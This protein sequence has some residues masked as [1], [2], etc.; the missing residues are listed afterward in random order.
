MLVRVVASYVAAIVAAAVLACIVNTQFTLAGLASFGMEVSLSDRLSATVHDVL[1]MGPPYMVV[2]AVGFVIAFVF[3][4]IL[5]RWVPGSRTVWF[6]AAGA[7]AVVAAI[8]IIKYNLGGTVVGAA[9]TPLG[10][11][12]QALAGAAGGWLFARLLPGRDTA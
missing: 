1:G 2:L 10:L 4:A 12:G 6:S 3:T 8:L 7:V 5:L 9:R 11:G